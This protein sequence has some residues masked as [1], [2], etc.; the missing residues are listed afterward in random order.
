M[1]MSTDKLCPSPPPKEKKKK[2]ILFFFCF[3][4]SSHNCKEYERLIAVIPYVIA[5]IQILWVA[6][7]AECVLV[8]STAV[9]LFP[10]YLHRVTYVCRVCC[11]LVHCGTA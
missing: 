2:K 6:G 7:V 1:V 11:W 5:A 9:S 3:P 8:H 10:D 4:I